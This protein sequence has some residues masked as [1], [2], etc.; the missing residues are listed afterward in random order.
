MNGVV[1]LLTAFALVVGMAGSA[2]AQK[3]KASAF[4]TAVKEGLKAYKAKDFDRAIVAF[5]RAYA[6]RPE[7]EMVFNIA[8]SH[9][10]AQHLDQAIADYEKFLVLEGTTAGL[11]ARA[12]KSLSSLRAEKTARLEAATAAA[13][14]PPPA[15]CAP[16]GPTRAPVGDRRATCG[17]RRIRQSSPRVVIVW[18][19]VSGRSRGRRLRRPGR[20]QPQRL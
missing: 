11:R 15:S 2:H 12:L 19:W 14:P 17:P 5:E 4:D 16:S 3:K 18:R 9:E 20:D 6:I 1:H 7:P 8:R 10:K 13:A